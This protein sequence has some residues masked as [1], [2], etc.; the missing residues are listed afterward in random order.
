VKVN[1]TPQSVCTHLRP[2]APPRLR[3]C[4]RSL[5]VPETLQVPERRAASAPQGD[6]DEDASAAQHSG[7]RYCVARLRTA[8]PSGMI[9]SRNA[10]R[11]ASAVA[12]PA[13]STV[14]TGSGQGPA[15]Q[16]Q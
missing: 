1:K 3:K 4:P 15:Q 13:A 9:R 11:G 8:E 7:R 5:Q 14:A 6:P 12:V 16:G 2:T 10:Q